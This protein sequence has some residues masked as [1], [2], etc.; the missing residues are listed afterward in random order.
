MMRRSL[1][2]CVALLALTA[3]AS[4]IGDTDYAQE[5]AALERQ[6]VLIDAVVAMLSFA[7]SQQ[8]NVL[9]LL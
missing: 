7:N 8:A 2:V 6:N 5:T 4:L 9:A 1:C 3:A